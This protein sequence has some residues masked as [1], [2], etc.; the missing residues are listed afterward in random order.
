MSPTRHLSQFITRHAESLLG[1]VP[2]RG[3]VLLFGGVQLSCDGA[4]H[5]ASCDGATHRASCDGATHRASSDGAI[6]VVDE[7]GMRGVTLLIVRSCATT[8][9]SSEG[10]VFV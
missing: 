4:T 3:G 9:T 10:R 6:M 2:R 8:L 7:R 1:S 5:R